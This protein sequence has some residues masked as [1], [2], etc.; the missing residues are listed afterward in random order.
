MAGKI[1]AADIGTNNSNGR[2]Q[3]T[4]ENITALSNQADDGGFSK[5]QILMD[6]NTHPTI[7]QTDPTNSYSQ[8]MYNSNNLFS[9]DYLSSHTYTHRFR[10]GTLNPYGGISTGR[11][12]LFFTKPDLHISLMDDYGNLNGEVINPSLANY[13]FWVDLYNNRRPIIESL[14]LSMSKNKDPFNHL[15]GN[16]V[17]SNL[18]LPSLDADITETPTN[19]YGVNYSYRGSSENKD[20][21]PEFSL[22]F[23]DTR[24]LDIYYYFKAYEEYETLKHHGTI[25]PCKKYI[26]NHILHDQ[27]AI[28]K[29][30]VDEDMETIIYWGKM[31][32]VFPVSLPR[33]VFSSPNWD[34]GLSYSINFRAAFYEDMKPEII[35]DFNNISA[36]IYNACKY[37]IDVYNPSLGRVDN[38]PAKAAYIEQVFNTAKRDYNVKKSV[39]ANNSP[40]GYLYKLRWKGDDKY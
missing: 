6:K 25:A 34:N 27:F 33:E 5:D 14:Q 13:P 18:D 15:L 36:P 22:E 31:Y 4:E 29:F 23:K 38:R 1:V 12:Y 30:I 40:S 28:Y 7:D 35:S 8:L 16:R 20:D 39:S 19:M 17:S 24:Y 3:T 2:I 32:G 10:F 9:R 37:K 11:E 26:T 21:N